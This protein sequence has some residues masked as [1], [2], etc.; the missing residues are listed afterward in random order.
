MSVGVTIR[1]Y[2]KQVRVTKKESA[3]LLKK[4]VQVTKAEGTNELKRKVPVTKTVGASSKNIT[5]YV[6]LASQCRTRRA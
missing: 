1:S 3:T 2:L 4:R 6:S 5:K